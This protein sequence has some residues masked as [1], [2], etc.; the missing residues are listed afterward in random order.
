M[1]EN[2]HTIPVENRS[3]IAAMREVIGLAVS[4]DGSWLRWDDPGLLAPLDEFEAQ[5]EILNRWAPVYQALENHEIACEPF[6][7]TVARDALASWARQRIAS[8]G[9]AD[10]RAMHAALAGLLTRME[11]A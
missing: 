5:R 10:A 8:G 6:V 2:M 9:D 1:T 4:A 3:E 11:A 7:V